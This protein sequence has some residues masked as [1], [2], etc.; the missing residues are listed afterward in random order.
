MPLLIL[1]KARVFREKP[2]KSISVLLSNR[3]FTIY[4]F[5][6]IENHRIKYSLKIVLS[7][8]LRRKVPISSETIRKDIE[9]LGS[10]AVW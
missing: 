9:E 6:L 7:V 4:Y 8:C 5:R 2:Q 10:A 1:G 3:N